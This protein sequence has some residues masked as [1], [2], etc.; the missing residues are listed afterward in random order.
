MAK[1][2]E[3]ADSSTPNWETTRW[4][5]RSHTKSNL[6]HCQSKDSAYEVVNASGSSG[7]VG[8]G[9]LIIS[10]EILKYS[11]YLSEKRITKRSLWTTKKIMNDYL[12][13]P[14]EVITY[15]N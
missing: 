7:R 11:K 13:S 1:E 8:V 5:H 14:L 6:Q 2:W 9:E 15:I 4:Q 12:A 10:K 3:C